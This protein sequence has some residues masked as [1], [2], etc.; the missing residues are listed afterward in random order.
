[1]VDKGRQ[2]GSTM[3]VEPSREGWVRG[4]RPSPKVSNKYS[5]ISLNERVGMLEVNETGC[6]NWFDFIH[7]EGC[8]DSI[9]LKRTTKIRF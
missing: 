7:V 3:H 8:G 9:S 6:R 4:E 1:M 2:L 5:L